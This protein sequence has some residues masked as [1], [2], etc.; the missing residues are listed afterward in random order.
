MNNYDYDRIRDDLKD[1]F[2][3]AMCNGYPMVVMNLSDVEHA[4]D[5]KLLRIAQDEGYD[6]S[7]YRTSGRF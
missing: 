3:T 5:D 4:A 2:G 6:L 7:M 1:H